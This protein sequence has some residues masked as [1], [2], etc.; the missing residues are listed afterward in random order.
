MTKR[1]L[2]V[3]AK[4]Y[5]LSILCQDDSGE[6]VEQEL[7]VEIARNEAIKKIMKYLPDSGGNI[8]AS[9]DQCLEYAKLY[10]NKSKG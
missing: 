4:I 3:A 8:P 1:E 2:K 5:S 9:K 7:M 6:C 10:C